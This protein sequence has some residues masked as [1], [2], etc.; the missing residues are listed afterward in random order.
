MQDG[1]EGWLVQR[2]RRKVETPDPESGM[3]CTASQLAHSIAAW[4]SMPPEF[5]PLENLIYG[6]IRNSSMFVETEFLSLAQGLESLH[7]LTDSRTL[8]DKMTFKTVLKTLLQSIRRV[9]QNSALADR[10]SDS[11][12]YANEPSFKNRIEALVARVEP[13][14]V[15][16]LLGDAKK[17]EQILRAT[18][19]F[20][21]HPG[22]AQNSKVLTSSKDIFL[23]NQKLHSFLRLLMLLYVGFLEDTIF[24]AVRHQ[25]KKWR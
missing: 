9:C 14:H 6:T 20:F 7:R 23:F 3:R 25:P 2:L 18:R 5:R 19:N 13:A 10:M 21:T 1:K 16:E 11:I 17:F 8:T 22:I 4:L 15:S 24:E 12:R